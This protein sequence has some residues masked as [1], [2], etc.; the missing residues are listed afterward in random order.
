MRLLH[1]RCRSQWR[2][3][4]RIVLGPALS[5]YRRAEI[6]DFSTNSG[7]HSLLKVAGRS[8]REVL[9]S[10]ARRSVT[11]RPKTI[12]SQFAIGTYSRE[13]TSS[14]KAPRT[15]TNSRSVLSVMH[16]PP[17]IKTQSRRSSFARGRGRRPNPSSQAENPLE[18]A[19]RQT[20]P[21]PLLD[22]PGP[23]DANQRVPFRRCQAAPSATNT[24]N[25]ACCGAIKTVRHS[26]N[27]LK[28]RVRSG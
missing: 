6:S 10:S 16:K 13:A 28:T 18:T 5:R 11:G 7:C 23:P 1:P 21:N 9:K 14:E 8:M 27:A 20:A 2:T 12:R 4:D 26:R 17:S 25:M 22:S 3:V 15:V 24:P 19:G